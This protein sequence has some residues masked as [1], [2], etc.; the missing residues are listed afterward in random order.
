MRRID[1]DRLDTCQNAL[2]Q[3]I[4]IEIHSQCDIRFA[5]RHHGQCGYKAVGRHG[6]CLI[7]QRGKDIFYE[8][9]C[10]MI[11]NPLNPHH[12]TSEP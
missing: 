6:G 4:G 7:P 12:L 3:E 5:L 11:G 9:D 10:A 2:V 1:K 8:F